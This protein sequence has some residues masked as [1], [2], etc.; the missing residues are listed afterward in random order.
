[1]R[2][3]LYRVFYH[4]ARHGSISEAARQLFASQPA[5]SQS[6]RHLED[7]LG[8]KLFVRGS[9]GVSLTAEGAVLYDYVQRGYNTFLT[10]ERALRDVLTLQ[11]GEVR[12]GGSDTLCKHVL[13]PVLRRFMSNH[14][15]IKIRVTNRTT[16]ESLE[17]LRRQEVDMALVHL[18]VA[19]DEFTLTPIRQITDCFVA[20]ERFR[21]ALS[22]PLHASELTRLPLLV[23]ER[24]TNTREALDDWAAR[25]G[26]VLIPEVELGSVDLL[27][28]FARIGLGLAYVVRDFVERDLSEGELFEARLVDPPPERTVGLATN[29]AMPLSR[30]AQEFMQMVIDAD[31]GGATA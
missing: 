22:R 4:V 21:E 17:L 3:E 31:K 9:R 10:G 23:L 26:V 14:P 18:P 5:V 27:V 7:H 15:Q 12:I 13:L 8:A 6:I 1:M 2:L 24:G 30:A 25:Q 28:E 20:G 16:P 19:S 11:S 29:A